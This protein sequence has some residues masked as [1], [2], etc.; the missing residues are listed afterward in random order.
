LAPV[1]LLGRVLYVALVYALSL[2]IELPAAFMAGLSLLGGWPGI[3]LM[4]AV[5]PPVA[6]MRRSRRPA[7]AEAVREPRARILARGAK[8]ADGGKAAYFDGIA[9]KW[10]GW[11]DLPSLSVK[12]AAGLAELGLGPSET[13]LDAG[14]GTGNLTREI[15]AKLCPA[16]RVVAVDFA[17][18]MIKRARRKVRDLRVRWHVADVGRLP[19][20]DAS[21]DRVL[22]FSLW[23]HI[24]D[25]DAVAA[26]LGRVLRPGGHL[27]IWH[28]ASRGKI[29]E[30]HAC[31]GGP[32][33]HDLLPPAG[34]TAALLSRHGFAVTAQ[35]DDETGYLVSAVRNGLPAA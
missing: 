19:I 6:R 8:K 27:H 21:C 35:V 13:V 11:E 3:V 7:D 30:V 14:C 20:P 34:E 5:V 25:R 26:E 2:A 22:C 29:N 28:L 15:L 1:L 12:L 33:G 16:G 23:P 17:P 31:A 24:D 9:G 4:M 10:D 32:I 18:R